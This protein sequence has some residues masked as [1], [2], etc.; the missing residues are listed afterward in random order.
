MRL[1]PPFFVQ[2]W[3]GRVFHSPGGG[4]VAPVTHSFQKEVED[5]LF[6]KSTGVCLLVI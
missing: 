3:K 2:G 6:F 4:R 1:S 5:P